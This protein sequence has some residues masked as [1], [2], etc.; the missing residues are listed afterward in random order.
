MKRWERYSAY[1]EKGDWHCHT[2]YTDGR[3][4][5]NE[6]CRQA[7]KNGLKIIAFTEHV[8]KSLS[9]DFGRF[10][11]DVDAARKRFPILKILAGCEAKVLDSEGNLDASREVLEQCDIVLG[12]FHSFPSLNEGGFSP[13]GVSGRLPSSARLPSISG[14]EELEQA[15]MNMLRNP[16]VDIWT[17]PITFFQKCP[18]CE[19]DV[20]EIIKMAMKSK[21]LI[22][23]NLRPRYRSPGLIETCRRMGAGIAI[24]SDAHGKE[25]LRNMNSLSK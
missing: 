19:K 17:H 8:R 22:E 12:T 2:K 10:L 18:L 3:N 1:L 24:G 4:T 5:V 25:D 7:E 6:M 23:D 16:E 20:H 14:K 11:K 13:E 15:L 9:Y 21:V